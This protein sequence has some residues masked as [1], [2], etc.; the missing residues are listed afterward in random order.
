MAGEYLQ[1]GIY[2]A[3]GTR[4]GRFF[5]IMFLKIQDGFS[6][7]DVGNTL[8]H[9]WQMYQDL[10]TGIV[11][12]LPGHPVEKPKEGQEP[13]TRTLTVLIGYGPQ[14]FNQQDG[15]YQPRQSLPKALKNFS[16]PENSEPILENAGL[17]YA[18]NVQQSHPNVQACQV[19]LQFIAETPLAAYRPV[20]ETWKLLYDLNPNPEEAPLK[21]ITFYSGF[22]REDR[23][24]W[25]DFHD[26][27]SNMKS[28][29]RVY[30]IETGGN[31]TGSD[32]WTC[33]GTY[34]AF[35]RINIDLA[36]WRSLSCSQQEIYV[37][38]SK[39]TGCPLEKMNSEDKPIPVSGCPLSGT[40]VVDRE[41]NDFR[42]PKT[43]DD[44]F[45]KN[46]HVQRA[47]HRES[48]PN[49]IDSRRIFRQGYEFLET[50]KRYSGFTAGLNFVSFQDHPDRL[51]GILG[52]DGWLGEVNF[53]GE[54]GN[55][56]DFLTV[57]AAG[58]YVVPPTKDKGFP[59]SGIF[60]SDEEISAASQEVIRPKPDCV[61]K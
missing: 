7:R 42:E 35:I 47:N 2:Y 45:L 54:E 22:N 31:E 38:R 24:S 6:A 40:E 13:L 21:L 23:R 56:E 12:D 9:L 16:T 53:G 10:K 18:P 1:E 57:Q 55:L 32:E 19:M 39:L 41:D 20:V 11:W 34:L 61:Q 29:Q 17:K 43:V 60:L 30:A 28:S 8:Y 44:P 48:Q 26:G 27:V 58:M 52:D 25:I 3:G 36:I 37:G 14:C 50:S 49:K 33:G 51:T 46:S 5:S 4:P 59:G 15:A